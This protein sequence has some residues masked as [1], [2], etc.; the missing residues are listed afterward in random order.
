MDWFERW[1]REDSFDER[2]LAL[3]D[4]ITY[5]DATEKLFDDYEPAKGA[6]RFAERLKKWL[7][8]VDTEAERRVLFRLLEH[9]YYVDQREFDVLYQQAFRTHVMWWLHDS[10]TEILTADAG[11]RLDKALAETWF[12]P[13]T[14]SFQI[15]R[16]HHINGLRGK[17][18]RPD[19][20]TLVRLGDP[21]KIRDYMEANGLRRLVLLEDFV[22]SGRQASAALRHAASL[23]RSPGDIPVLVVPMVIA[24]GGNDCLRGIA[25]EFE[26]HVTFAPMVILGSETVIS[27]VPS[28]GEPAFFADIRPLLADWQA[29]VDAKGPDE[30]TRVFGF[31]KT[32]AAVAMYSNTPNNSLP[33]LHHESSTWSPLFPRAKRL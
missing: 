7:S 4:R 21:Q 26:N 28:N 10:I 31:G 11:T 5:L 22:G 29:L 30:E 27:P 18:L 20:R 17:D 19:W 32:G 8:N 13:I 25:G 2:V 23:G 14:D 33:V 1:R 16:F 6:E 9:L 3:Y 24:P 12:C 15:A